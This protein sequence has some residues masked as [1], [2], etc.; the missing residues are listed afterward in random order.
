MTNE[1]T[2]WNYKPTSLLII[3][4]LY[5]YFCI[6]V[7][8]NFHPASVCATK[9][10]VVCSLAGDCEHFSGWVRGLVLALY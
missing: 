9:I 10:E 3:Y 7:I 2:Q 1:C 5:I 8:V 6:V 4:M